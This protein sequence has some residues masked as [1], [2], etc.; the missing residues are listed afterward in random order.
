[1]G[2][3]IELDQFCNPFRASAKVACQA[4]SSLAGHQ[5]PGQ[6]AGMPSAVWHNQPKLKTRPRLSSRRRRQG[7]H[8]AATVSAS[9]DIQGKDRNTVQAADRPARHA[10]DAEPPRVGFRPTQVI[11]N[12]PVR[13][14]ETGGVGT[15]AGRGTQSRATASD[16]RESV[17]PARKC[18]PVEAVGHCAVGLNGCYQASARKTDQVESWPA[19]CTG[20]AEQAWGTPVRVPHGNY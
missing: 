18:N 5:T 16:G 11:E 9:S 8:H 7:L 13:R 1:M 2:V 12:P 4:A 17:E 20:S 3:K 15:Q 19:R 14:P 10:S 6:L